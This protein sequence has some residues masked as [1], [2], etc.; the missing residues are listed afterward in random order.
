MFASINLSSATAVSRGYDFLGTI[1]KPEQKRRTSSDYVEQIYAFPEPTVPKEIR[2]PRPIFQKGEEFFTLPKFPTVDT[3]RFSIVTGLGQNIR[4][5]QILSTK[6]LIGTGQRLTPDTAIIQKQIQNPFQDEILR[7]KQPQRLRQNQILET[8]Q[9][10]LQLQQFE[11]IR[12][13]KFTYDFKA[14]A[15]GKIFPFGGISGA[16]R[17]FGRGGRVFKVFDVAKVPAGKVKVGVGYYEVSPT[18]IYEIK[19]RRKTKDEFFDIY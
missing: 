12:P 8:P 10:F 13:P 1:Q 6:D 7:Q 15:V 2:Q 4:P 3:G 16:V 18:P 14:P 19:K 11:Q 5:E 17:S 9:K